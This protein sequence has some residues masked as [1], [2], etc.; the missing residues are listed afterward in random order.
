MCNGILWGQ[1][2]KQMQIM[3]RTTVYEIAGNPEDVAATHAG[4]NGAGK[5]YGCITRGKG[6]R[7]EIL[8]AT[9]PMFDTAEAADDAMRQLIDAVTAWLDGD[10]KNPQNTFVNLLTGKESPVIRRILVAAAAAN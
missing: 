9:P 8:F 6:R 3:P 7:Y 4:P 2:E 10:L 5:Y 1:E